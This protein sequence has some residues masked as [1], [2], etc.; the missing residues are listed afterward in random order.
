MP[1]ELRR[2]LTNA[3]P[4]KGRSGGS[5]GGGGGSGNVG[6]TTLNSINWA[7]PSAFGSK[8]ELKTVDVETVW[9]DFQRN[10][11]TQTE[12]TRVE[13]QKRLIREAQESGKPF[14]SPALSFTSAAAARRLG[15]KPGFDIADGRHRLTAFRELGFK[16]IKARVDEE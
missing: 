10:G 13:T 14:R 8:S 1:Q 6:K 12:R 15:T 2:L 4:S 16:K 3:V 5:G 9:K 11:F 7:S